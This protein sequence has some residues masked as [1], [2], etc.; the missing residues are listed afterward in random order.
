ME[1]ELKE[2]FSFIYK[3]DV[4][5]G[6]IEYEFDHVFVGISDNI[7]LINK[8]EVDSYKY[9]TVENIKSGIEKNPESYTAWFKIAFAKLCDVIEK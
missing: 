8:E 6:L 9:D 2:L 5:Q 3:A 4:M 7:P 1:C